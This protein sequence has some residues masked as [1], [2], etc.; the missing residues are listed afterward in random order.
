MISLAQK[1]ST[2]CSSSHLLLQFQNWR[3]SS[4]WNL[5]DNI[6]GKQDKRHKWDSMQ[7]ECCLRMLVILDR[8]V[9]NRQMSVKT[10]TTKTESPLSLAFC[11]PS[12]EFE[13]W[14]DMLKSLPQSFFW[15][16]RST[17]TLT[18]TQL[19]PP[20]QW[21]V[22]TDPIILWG[23]LYW[24]IVEAGPHDILVCPGISH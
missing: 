16:Y 12:P 7:G 6:P 4:C 8:S 21:K 18:L 3:P 14:K 23:N 9:W 15:L 13:N 20:L 5:V 1:E 10:K 2:S 17:E 24:S 11:G 19:H 22:W